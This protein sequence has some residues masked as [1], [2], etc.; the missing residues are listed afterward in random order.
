MIRLSIG[1]LGAMLIALRVTTRYCLHQGPAMD[2][3]LFFPTLEGLTNST[4]RTVS[5]FKLMGDPGESY[6]EMVLAIAEAKVSVTMETY[7]FWSGKAADAFVS[8]LCERA[9]AGVPVKLLFDADVE[10]ATAA[11]EA[12][13][14]LTER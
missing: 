3:P 8:A 13:N 5:R 9:R 10:V 7:L 14:A 11:Q 6:A 2:D 4:S 12:L 1:A